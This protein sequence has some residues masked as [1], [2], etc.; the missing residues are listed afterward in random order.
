[1]AAST[2]ATADRACPAKTARA[3]FER[4]WRGKAAPS[5]GAGLG[6]AIVAEIMK[7]HGGSV[8]V[9]AGPQGGAIFTLIFTPASGRASVT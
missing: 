8:E 5:H 7:A 1:M 2:S 9:D 4:F 6:L 3:I